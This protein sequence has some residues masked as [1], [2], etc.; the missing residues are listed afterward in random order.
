MSASNVAK[1]RIRHKLAAR[2]VICV[3]LAQP[4][5]PLKLLDAKTVLLEHL[6]PLQ[7]PL[8]APNVRLVPL[9]VPHKVLHAVHVLSDT[10]LWASATLSVA[11]VLLADLSMSLVKKTVLI[12]E[13]DFLS[14][15]LGSLCAC[16]V[17]RVHSART[18]VHLRAKNVHWV[19]F[20]IK[21]APLHA[22]N[23]L[24]VRMLHYLVARRVCNVQLVPSAA[25]LVSH[26][27]QSAPQDPT[28]LAL[29]IL[30]ACYVQSASS[31]PQLANP[32]VSSVWLEQPTLL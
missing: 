12:V 28:L 1:E 25:F 19:D 10:F 18:I 15:I 7:A 26:S 4:F 23:A 6:L 21:S 30:G 17:L 32:R 16:S 22:P 29:P 11:H 31:N 27:V 14:Q 3:L 13:G 9:L 8:R 24:P 2:R 20:R 5:P